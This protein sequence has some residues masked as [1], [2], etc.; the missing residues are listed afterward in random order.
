MPSI[1]RLDGSRLSLDSADAL[2]R[3]LVA[4]HRITG[5]QVAVVARGRLAWSGAY[6]IRARGDGVG[7][8]PAG[9]DLP[10]TR[11]TTT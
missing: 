1:V 10:M 4:E 3:A 5:L 2:V 11:T 7:S 9:P 6:G 8:A